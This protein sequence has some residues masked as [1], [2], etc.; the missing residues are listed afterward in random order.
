MGKSGGGENGC[1]QSC[2][3]M[4][5]ARLSEHLMKAGTVLGHRAL[6]MCSCPLHALPAKVTSS[7][8]RSVHQSAGVK[9]RCSSATVH[10][11]CPLS[12]RPWKR[13]IHPEE[14]EQVPVPPAGREGSCWN[15]T[16][17]HGLHFKRAACGQM[18]PMTPDQMGD[19][20]LVPHGLP[21]NSCTYGTGGAALIKCLTDF[22]VSE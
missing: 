20:C 16:G 21:L 12:E 2:C 14:P 19:G 15:A 3:G 8:S 6:L 10:P 11:C 4:A 22:S 5:V 9:V 18:L 7:V 1:F 17:S 13:S